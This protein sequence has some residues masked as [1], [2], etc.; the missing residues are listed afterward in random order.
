MD[1]KTACTR[2]VGVLHDGGVLI[3]ELVSTGDVADDLYLQRIIN[4]LTTVRQSM[5]DGLEQSVT[6]L[7]YPL[8]KLMNAKNSGGNTT[9]DVSQWATVPDEIRVGCEPHMA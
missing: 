7:L 6:D 8:E 3:S 2:A 5:P 9:I 1:A 4:E